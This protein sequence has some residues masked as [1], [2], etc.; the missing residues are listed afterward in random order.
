MRSVI[1]NKRRAASWMLL[2][3]L[4]ALW[5]APIYAED[6]LE[7]AAAEQPPAG[8]EDQPE[9]GP[10]KEVVG[11]P[12][13]ITL[14]V[15]I[16][17]TLEFPFEI[18]PI[19]LTDSSLFVFRRIRA[20]GKTRKLLLVPKGPG[21]TDMTVHD[22]SG[23]PRITYYVRVTREDL[24]Q[25]I[26]QLE[27]LLGDIEG[28]RIKPVGGTVV[29]DGDILLP[30]DIV[31]IIRVV[32]ALKDR[33]AK[34]KNV[35]IKNVAQIS[36]VTM[37]I[38]AERIEREIGSPDIQVRVLNNNILMEG[39]AQGNFEADRAIEIAKTYLPEV[40]V[41]KNKADEGEVKPKQAGGQT[42]GLP[43][44]IDLLRIAPPPASAPGKD[45]KITMNYVE[46][47]NEYDKTFNFVWSPLVSDSSNFQYNSGLGELSANLV[48]TVSSLF[49]K[50]NSA[51]SHGH[52]KILKT[53]QII[54]K[55]RAEQ[56]AAI[57][58]SVDFFTR[59]VDATGNSALTPVQV[60]NVTKV[61]A[62]TIPGSDSLELGLQ[63]T[64]NS[65]LGTNQGAPIIAKNSLQTQVII[66]NGDSAALGGFAV[67][68]A[69]SG[70]NR[71]PDRNVSGGGQGQQQGSPLFNLNR[72]KNFRRNKQ[73][74]II[75]VTPEV[76]R[77]ASAG[78]ED[79]TR[80]FRLNAGE[81]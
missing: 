47:T 2:L 41:Q 79:I 48:A 24:G 38:I 3:F 66:K 74:Y 73:Q 72:G 55:D 32:D 29:I 64:L 62:A 8:L 25:I 63:I 43:I 40:F 67:D 75:F 49:P 13:N 36:R 10:I 17:R 71:E 14:S 39:T 27:E 30:K 21:Y 23:A 65:L 54:V 44:I 45:I 81:R 80:K 19:Y 16:S 35:P 22:A 28:I 33:D 57:E 42:G 50:L 51:K 11:E 60:Q 7:E 6:T 58:S 5:A 69:L 53:E 34:K 46:L 37:N 70:Y 31:R 52:A 26:S 76:I 61:K 56:P 18:G 12:R 20:G 9:G 78:T 1:K 77:T 68:E 59:T 15:G 4:C